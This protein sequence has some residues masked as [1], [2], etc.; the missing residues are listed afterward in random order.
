LAKPARL[1]PTLHA[2]ARQS[3]TGVKLLQVTAW[4]DIVE[5]A[6]SIDIVQKQGL[7]L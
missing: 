3:I 5:T 6:C 7:H 2:A 4:Q 1:P